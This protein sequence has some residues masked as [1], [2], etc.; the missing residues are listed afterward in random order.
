MADADVRGGDAARA[1]ELESVLAGCR[2]SHARLLGV[3]VGLDEAG[4]RAPSRLDGWTVGHVL[5]HLARNADSH[6]RM[7]SAALRGE[8]V[9]QYAGGREERAGS[10]EA[11][12]DRPA[13]ELR[14]DVERSTAGLEATWAAM[15]PEAWD[16]HGLSRGRPWPCRSLPFFRWREVEIH[17]VD[18]G[19]GYGP[20][21]W[22]EEYV[23]RELP[24]LL[25]TVPDRLADEAERRRLLAWL[26]GRSPSSGELDLGPWES[27]PGNYFGASRR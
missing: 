3:V 17:H 14:H 15:T 12:A 16:G 5:T 4:V 2:A 1:A 8:A 9:E 21:D 26:T 11:G 18:A 23:R 19:T 13:S 10:I 20:Q 7:L 25:A 27:R 24:L 6:T 22:P